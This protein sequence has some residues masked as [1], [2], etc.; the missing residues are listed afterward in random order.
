MSM[1]GRVMRFH[2]RLVRGRCR[3]AL[4]EMR[5][6]AIRVAVTSAALCC[7]LLPPTDTLLLLRGGVV[8]VRP[9]TGGRHARCRVTFPALIGCDGIP[10]PE[11]FAHQCEESLIHDICYL[12]F[13]IL[14]DNHAVNTTSRVCGHFFSSNTHSLCVCVCDKSH[15]DW[16]CW[17][18]FDKIGSEKNVI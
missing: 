16:F 2:L 8:L 7:P 12:I 10:S 14:S 3:P 1:T 6:M 11:E 17:L 15:Y 13:I 9:D 18:L 4:T 5:G